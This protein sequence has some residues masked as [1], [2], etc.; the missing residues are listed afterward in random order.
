MSVDMRSYPLISSMDFSETGLGLRMSL[1][2][3]PYVTSNAK[4]DFVAIF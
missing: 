1:P 4:Q 2:G 3:K